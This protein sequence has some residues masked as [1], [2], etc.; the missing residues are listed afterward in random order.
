[1]WAAERPLRSGAI[2]MPTLVEITTSGRFARLAETQGATR[3]P[4]RPKSA[5]LHGKSPDVNEG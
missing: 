5:K 2:S 3:K 4:E 1:M